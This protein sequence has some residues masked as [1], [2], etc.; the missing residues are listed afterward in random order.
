MGA[1]LT[2][3][4]QQRLS[5]ANQASFLAWFENHSEAVAISPFLPRN[6]ESDTAIDMTGLLNQMGL[7]TAP[8]REVPQREAT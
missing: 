6:T 1:F 2:W 4:D 3:I 5:G 7:K 8:N